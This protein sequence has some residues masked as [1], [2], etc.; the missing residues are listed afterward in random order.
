MSD[1]LRRAAAPLGLLIVLIVAIA[2]PI[3][4]E[5]DLAQ[6]DSEAAEGFAKLV[7]TI[8]EDSSVL[9]GFDP[10][11]GTYAEIRPTVR[12]AIAA[13]AERGVAFVL[14]SLTPEGRALAIEERGSLVEGGADSASLADLGFIPGSEAA[15][16]RIANGLSG[17]SALGTTARAELAR[18]DVVLVVGGNDIGPRSWVEQVAPRVTSIRLAAISPTILLPEVAPYAETGQLVASISNPRD[19]AAL[20]D[21]LAAPTGSANDDGPPVG[22]VLIGLAAAIAF[23][24]EG[25]VRWSLRTARPR[26]EREAA[27]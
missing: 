25:L 4:D 24:G 12:A 10:D 8:P 11:I 9:L 1:A 27:G 21:L 5:L 22:A 14:V 17:S 23:L 20:R 15:L 19:G 26:P 6:P 7:A 3:G 18:V 13:L 2:L 16:V